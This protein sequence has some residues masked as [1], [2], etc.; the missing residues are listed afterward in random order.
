MNKSKKILIISPFAR[1]NIGGVETHIDKIISCTRD[2]EYYPVVLTYQPITNKGKGLKHEYGDGYE[3]HR[4]N[5]FGIG[6]FS[7][8][9]KYYPLTFLYL[10]PG[11]FIWSLIYYLKHYKDIYCIHA[12]GLV[13]ALIAVLLSKIHIKR[14][15]VST[16]AIYSFKD[17]K[18]LSRLV[19]F[20]L[21]SC[22]GLIP[23]SEMSKKEL[24]EMGI[25]ENRISVFVNWMDTEIFKPY[26][27]NEV[28]RELNIPYKYNF[29]FVGRLLEKKG[30][31]LFLETGEK[32]KDYGFHIVGGGDMEGEVREKASRNKNIMY[33][34]FLRHSSEEEMKKLVYLYNA[35]DFMISP[36]LYDEGYAA[37][38]IESLSCGTPLIVTGRGSPP[39]FLNDSVAYYL[40]PNPTSDELIEAVRYLT[41]E[42]NNI[43]RTDICRDY[44]LKY[45]SPKN[46][47][48]IF[49]MYEPNR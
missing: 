11:L 17:R 47:D 24:I 48:I 7:K 46:A 18:L 30:I 8:I 34:G 14:V 36:Y 44:A 32:Y 39:S 45:F 1:P 41:N 15:V 28:K 10:F 6:L 27:K 49:K 35:C 43:Y 37:V 4:T 16:H 13:S 25:E 12:H 26:N 40:S 31:K 42:G 38:L 19:K 20:I 29:I 9:E 22:D 21:K 2:K 3:Y 33:Y 23:V 5:W